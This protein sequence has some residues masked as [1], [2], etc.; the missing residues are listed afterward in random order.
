MQWIPF[1]AFSPRVSNRIGRV[2]TT[3]GTCTYTALSHSFKS[4]LFHCMSSHDHYIFPWNMCNKS[5]AN[6]L[7]NRKVASL[8]SKL[9]TALNLISCFSSHGSCV[10]TSKF[11]GIH[12]SLEKNIEHWLWTVY[13]IYLTWNAT[14]WLAV[15]SIPC[16]KC[17]CLIPKEEVWP[18][19]LL[20]TDTNKIKGWNFFF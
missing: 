8:Y 7:R 12:S 16:S 1:S 19:D 14:Q 9:M 15:F 18:S 11:F 20:S 6:K 3:N 4:N 13:F 17:P 5:D 10:S 2:L